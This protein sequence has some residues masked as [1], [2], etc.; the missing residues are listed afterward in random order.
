MLAKRK[1]VA[2]KNLETNLCLKLNEA[3]GQRSSLNLLAFSGSS[4]SGVSS[5]GGLIGRHDYQV[6]QDSSNWNRD[7]KVMQ[8]VI[9]GM[10]PDIVLR[11]TNTDENR[12][13]IEVKSTAKLNYKKEDSQVIRYFLHLLAM[14]KQNKGRDIRRGVILA[15]PESWFDHPKNGAW[16]NYFLE[17]YS[18]LARA[19]DI[20]L[21]ALN[22]DSLETR[23]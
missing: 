20:T 7:P 5:L 17:T 13:Y 19:F 16:W 9:G 21:A 8:D 3:K 10:T 11:S 2:E 1:S 18:D 15:A 4:S 6:I 12:I 23:G 22:T 14:T